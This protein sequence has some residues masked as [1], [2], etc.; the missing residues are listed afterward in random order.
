MRWFISEVTWHNGFRG[1]KLRSRVYWHGKPRTKVCRK[2]FNCGARMRRVSR[3]RNTKLRWL[4]W[5]QFP[6][7]ISRKC[8]F[9]SFSMVLTNFKHMHSILLS[10]FILPVV[11]PPQTAFIQK[12][13]SLSYENC[14]KNSKLMTL[15]LKSKQFES[16]LGFIRHE[17]SFEWKSDNTGRMT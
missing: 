15:A 13:K 2:V 10:P 17:H 7:R 4:L 11:E 14:I 5:K 1:G 12:M 9:P 8:S 3:E 6:S 16:F